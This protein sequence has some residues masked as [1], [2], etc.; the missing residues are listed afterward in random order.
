MGTLA[1]EQPGDLAARIHTAVAEG[2]KADWRGNTM[3]ERG[4]RNL[5]ATA[6]ETETGAVPSP[7]TIDAIFRI[8]K[9]QRDY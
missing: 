3:K 9:N 1:A 6:I 7:E 2:H 4:V 8:V 5:I